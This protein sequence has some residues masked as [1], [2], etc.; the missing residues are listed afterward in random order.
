MRPV[1]I[2]AACLAALT[3]FFAGGVMAQSAA[4]EQ[5][6]FDA[7]RAGGVIVLIRHG[8]TESGIGDP[9]EFRLGDCATQRNL[10]AGGREQSRRLGERLREAGVRFGEVRSSQWC[11]CLDT[12]EL[13]FGEQYEVRPWP[14]LNSLF[15][16]SGAR[17]RQTSEVHA[18]A[19]ELPPGENWVWVTHQFNINAYTGE[20]TAMGEMVLARPH[21][22]GLKVIG[23]LRP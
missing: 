3:F 9:P 10:S 11:R 16:D 21:E 5:E 22:G 4:S 14:A 6:M 12:A 8:V 18:R 13:A 20:Y 15:A 19:A 1:Q 2:P 23:K 7:L 17:A